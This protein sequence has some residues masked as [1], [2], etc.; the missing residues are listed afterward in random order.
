[1]T[2]PAEP[3]AAA[4]RPSDP[5]AAASRAPGAGR[6][7]LVHGAGAL[8]G[9]VSLAVAGTTL[10]GGWWAVV[11]LASVGVVSGRLGAVVH[12][13]ATVALVGGAASADTG[14][15]VPVLVVGVVASVEAG[16]E[17][18]RLNVVRH[19]VDAGRAVSATAV[20]GATSAALVLL[21]GVR[22]SAT[23]PAML[24]AAGASVAVLTALRR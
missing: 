24:L 12:A 10:G 8:V 16:A 2:P 9:L 6:G 4:S 11:A 17:R 20:A 3:A 23:V 18:H 1:M 22:P 7:R 21:G 13:V 19:R 15:L 14:W 5:A